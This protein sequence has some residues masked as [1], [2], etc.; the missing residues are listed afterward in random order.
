MAFMPI[1]IALIAGATALNVVGNI[2]QGNAAKA[3]ADY[4]SAVANMNAGQAKENQQIASQVGAAKTGMQEQQTRAQVGQMESNQAASGVQLNSGSFR[5][6]KTSENE[7]GQL[8]ALTVRGNATKEAFGYSVQGVN[9]KAEAQLDT[10]QG[11]NAQTAGYLNAGS[12]LLS[13][14]SKAATQYQDYKMQGGLS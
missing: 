2:Q 6:V 3:S 10:F 11:K 1:A 8:D 5:D 4:N 9:E 7:L 14:A 13:G 12:S